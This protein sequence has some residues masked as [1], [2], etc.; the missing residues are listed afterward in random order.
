MTLISIVEC[1]FLRQSAHVQA[2]LICVQA[3]EQ[4][5]PALLAEIDPALVS[6]YIYIM[7]MPDLKLN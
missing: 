6:I 5:N 3:V 7:C 1:A 4:N 2:L